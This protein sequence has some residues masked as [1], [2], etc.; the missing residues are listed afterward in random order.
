MM[1][2]A[3]SD[4]SGG[5]DFDE[6]CG[7]LELHTVQRNIIVSSSESTAELW[8][9]SHGFIYCAHDGKVLQLVALCSI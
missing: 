3:D 4:G 6:F 9:T 5:I 8:L 2:K 7:M 1:H